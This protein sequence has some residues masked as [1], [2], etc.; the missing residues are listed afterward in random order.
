MVQ[1]GW[2]NQV[3]RWFAEITR[4]RI[5]RGTFHTVRE[6]TKASD[7]YVRTYN[8]NPS[9]VTVSHCAR[10]GL[11]HAVPGVVGVADRDLVAVY[12]VGVAGCGRS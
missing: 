11:H 5:R 1:R 4:K 9:I 6:L 7:D 8:Y 2:L 12:I 3:E 10:V